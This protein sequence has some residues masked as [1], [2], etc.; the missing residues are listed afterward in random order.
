MATRVQ[1]G[2]VATRLRVVA[3]LMGSAIAI[4]DPDGPTGVDGNRPY[5]LTTF[6]SLD[7]SSER[8]ARGLIAWGVRPGMTLV[9][10]VPFGAKFIELTFALLKAGVVVVLIDP[11]MGRKHL[12]QCL[13]DAKPDG[14]V[15]IPKAQA[16]RTLLRG[17]FPNAKWNV[18]VGRKYFW[19]GKTIEQIAELGRTIADSS[20]L[21]K[22]QRPDPAAVIFT[23]GSTGPPKGV[24]YTHGTFHAQI[25]RIRERYDIHRGSRDLACFPLFGLFDA[26]MG[27]TTI[28][29]DM[30]PTRPADVDP[31]K[32]VEAAAQWE[33]DQAFGS[34]ALWNTVVRWA[35]ANDVRQPFPTLRRVL[36]AGAPVPAV[37]LEKLRTLLDPDAEI[38][39]PY[40]A[41]EALPIASIESREI[42]A[43]TGPASAKGKGVCVGTRFDDVLWKVIA[44]DDGP[45]TDIS[46]T[47]ELATRQDR[48]TDGRRSDGDDSLCRSRRSERAAQSRRR[49]SRLAPH[50]RRRLLGRTRPVLVLRSQGA[51]R[52]QRQ[53][54]MV[55]DPVRSDLQCASAGV[56]IG[57]G[58]SRRLPEPNAGDHRRTCRGRDEV[59]KLPPRRTDRGT[60]R[61]RRPQSADD[62]NRR[63][64]RSRSTAAGRHSSQQQD[65]PRTIGRRDREQALALRDQETTD[66]P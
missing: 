30:D 63:S 17:K 62:A 66:L 52:R 24:L 6:G 32:L 57:T 1:D 21:P 3:S 35:E 47:V 25:D 29:P 5:K 59:T 65:L 9:M 43:E 44:I 58:R 60:E 12:V 31:Q 46:Q 13:S 45:L 53:K 23:T 19:G 50:G 34:P 48:R 61:T 8:I 54:N 7:E 4:A 40:G 64:H 16:I 28:I 27:V 37:T 14:F 51:P 26:V 33:I 18:T 56:S 55:H 39:T 41:T 38:L 10:L 36:S 15:G 49:R 22:I 20:A 11:G 2:N 42:I